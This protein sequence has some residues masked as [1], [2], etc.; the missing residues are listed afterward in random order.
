MKAHREL[1]QIKYSYGNAHEK[2]TCALGAL[3]YYITKTRTCQWSEMN[4]T[5]RQYANELILISN[6]GNQFMITHYNDDLGWSFYKIAEKA[7]KAEKWL[8]R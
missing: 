3:V 8:H 6:L 2:T 4:A 1:K 7:R 5:E